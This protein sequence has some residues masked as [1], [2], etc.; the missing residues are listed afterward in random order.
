MSMK[1]MII[2]G[3]AHGENVGGKRSPDKRLEEYRFSREIV[4][5]LK[6][7]LEAAGC[8]V[9]VD[10]P[11]DRVPTPQT[12]ELRTRCAIVNDLCKKYGKE[13]CL[14]VS[15]H[16]NAAGGDG[17]WK[18]AGGWCAY[19]SRGQTTADLL[20][21]CL[22]KA[23]EDNLRGYA[24]LMEAGKKQGSY[25]QLQRPLRIDLSDGDRDMEAD[26]YVLK[27][28]ACAA[29]LTENLFMDNRSDVG[30]LLSDAGKRAIVGLH[31]EGILNFINE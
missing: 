6:S 18:Q 15:I 16:V 5:R 21:D 14:Y 7:E 26:F 17:A 11:S 13:N 30:F 31:K 27:H 3:T 24:R 2:L 19:T 8:T 4:A 28:T 23:A 25:G 1:K 22:Y 10:L 20:A 29:V 9:Y 12:E